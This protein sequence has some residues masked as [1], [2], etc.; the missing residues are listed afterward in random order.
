MSELYSTETTAD[1]FMEFDYKINIEFI[2]PREDAVYTIR[3]NT[4]VT[5]L[6][7]DN[8]DQDQDYGILFSDDE[9]EENTNKSNFL[10]NE[11]QNKQT[12]TI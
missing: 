7:T 4:E 3:L 2:Q 6:F 8:S 1:L 11:E 12:F 9:Y 10:T 5:N